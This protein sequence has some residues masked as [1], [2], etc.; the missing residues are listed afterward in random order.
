M[1]KVK[2]HPELR[3]KGSAIKFFTPHFGERGTKMLFK[4]CG[5][6]RGKHG[7]D[8]RYEQVFIPRDDG[9]G[10]R[11]CVY[12]PLQKDAPAVQNVPGL[13]WIHGGLPPACTFV[14]DI[15]PF[16][17]ETAAYAENLR[18]SGVPVHFKV[19]EGCFHAFDMVCPN[20][21]VAKEAAE[22]LESA[23]KYAVSNYFA[24]Q[25]THVS[26]V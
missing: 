26:H 19:F 11:I 21:S 24:E 3:F 6:M 7:K 13:L 2:L 20:T 25:A 18:K 8:L 9:T 1:G 22:L 17:D 16:Y 5:L 14:G 10:L 12:S 15:E 23:F 4:L